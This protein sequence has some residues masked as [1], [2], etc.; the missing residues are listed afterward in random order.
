MTDGE[1]FTVDCARR[2]AARDEL[3]AWV[4]GFLSSPGSDNAPLAH[5]LTHPPRTWIGPVRLPLDQ[6]NRL[7]G[8]PDH[9]VLVPVDDDEWRDDVDDLEDKV[10]EGWEPPPM[11]VTFRDDELH[12]EDGN[13]RVEGLRR[14][15]ERHAWAVVSFDAPEERDRFLARAPQS[16]PEDGP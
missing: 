12:L 4:A 1:R 15:G 3:G 10:G 2:A 16:V 14:A 9:P 7:A 5:K 8:P 11:I 13:H 6:L